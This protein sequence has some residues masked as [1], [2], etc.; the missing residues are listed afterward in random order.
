VNPVSQ[1]LIL[2]GAML[3]LL[4]GVGLLRFSTPYARFHAA[5]KASPIAFL[6]VGAGASI[7]VGLAGAAQLAV[8]AVALVLT[9]PAATHLLFRATHRTIDSPHL[10]DDA[11]ARAEALASSRRDERALDTSTDDARAARETDGTATTEAN[12]ATSETDD[13][14]PD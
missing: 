11:L 5:G 6:L 4:A 14:D 1:V 12:E 13:E 3:A 10:R 9:L 7:E 2:A 8:A